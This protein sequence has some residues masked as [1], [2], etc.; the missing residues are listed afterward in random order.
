MLDGIE[1]SSG[2][3]TADYALTVIRQICTWHAQRHDHYESPIVRGMSRGEKKSR[4]RI[5]TDDEIRALWSVTGE[6]SFGRLVRF[7]LLTAQR[8]DKLADMKWSD[9]DGNVWKIRTDPREKGNAG[10]LVLPDLAMDVLGPRGEGFVFP[11]Q[12]GNKHTAWG[13]YKDRLDKRSGV[14]GWR[15]HDLRRTARSLMSRARVQPHIA[16]L[17]LG[18]VQQG[19]EAIYDRH[20]DTGTRRATRLRR[21]R[22]W[23]G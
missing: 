21:S 5:L 18:H 9:L 22:G 6:S 16:E 7:G 11:T 15:L 1:D 8:R 3:R 13:D 20:T 14:T 4:D 12:Q 23:S 19:V 10:E 2:S 17:T